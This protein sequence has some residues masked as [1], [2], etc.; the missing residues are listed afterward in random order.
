MTT[1]EKELETKVANLEKAFLQ[2]A[3]NGAIQTQTVD[4]SKNN[5]AGLKSNDENH[6]AEITE[7]KETQAE[8]DDLLIELLNSL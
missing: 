1:K 3:E 6:D 8:Q 5:I 4:E 7:L 2:F